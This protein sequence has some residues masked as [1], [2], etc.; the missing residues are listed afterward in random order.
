MT[1]KV[2]L[3]VIG[4][5]PAGMAAA[6]EATKIDLPVTIIDLFEQ[7]GGNYYKY[8]PPGLE[9]NT[10]QDFRRYELVKGL[11]AKNVNLYSGCLVWGIFPQQ[12]GY[13]LCLSTTKDQPRRVLCESLIITAGAYDRPA[14]FPGWTL[15]GVMTA[16]AALHLVKHQGVLPGKRLLLS[17]SGPLQLLLAARLIEAGGQVAAVL[18]ANPFPWHGVRWAAHLWGQWPRLKEAAWAWRI[19]RKAKVPLHWDQ[20]IIQAQGQGRLEK[21]YSGPPGGPENKEYAVDTVCLGYGFTPAVQLSRL[22]GADHAYDPSLGCHIPIRDAWLQTSLPG[23]FVA[24]DGA[25][26][27]G[28]DTALAEGRLALLGA[29]RYLRM[30]SYKDRA[31]RAKRE[32]AKQR[33]FADLLSRLYPFPPALWDRLTDETILCRCE[34]VTLGQIR[35][36]ISEGANTVSAVRVLTRAGMGN[37]QGRMCGGSLAAVLSR[38]LGLDPQIL[39]PATPRPPIIPITLDEML[40]EPS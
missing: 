11:R 13:L 5:G 29:A 8:T 26:I 15:P 16:G 38:E 39:K 10:Q 18:E 7:P 4:A 23:L 25:A 36:V 33:R 32:L 22:A 19:L 3:A 2:R 21:V 24:G 28:K 27:G 1:E 37:C 17:G 14:P 34:E 20:T 40:E 31:H 35:Q 6:A 30:G 9:K 12:E